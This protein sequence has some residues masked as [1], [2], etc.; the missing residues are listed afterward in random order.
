MEP[1]AL[2]SCA[3]GP[4]D[5]IRQEMRADPPSHE[6]AKQSKIDHLNGFLRLPLKLDV[7]RD[8]PVQIGDP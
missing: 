5:R 8:H 4:L 1:D 3:E 7:A 2:C 6:L